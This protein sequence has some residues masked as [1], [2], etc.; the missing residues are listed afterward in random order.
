MSSYPLRSVQQQQQQHQQ[1]T[2]FKD[3][4]YEQNYDANVY[5]PA[6]KPVAP[7]TRFDENIDSEIRA[8]FSS[9][10]TTTENDVLRNAFSRTP[11]PK[12]EVASAKAVWDQQAFLQNLQFGQSGSQSPDLN[13]IIRQ[14]IASPN[15]ERFNRTVDDYLSFYPPGGY[16]M[17]LSVNESPRLD[18]RFLANV[19]H[20]TKMEP[21]LHADP[22]SGVSKLGAVFHHTDT[23]PAGTNLGAAFRQAD[24]RSRVPSLVDNS[25]LLPSKLSIDV[26]ANNVVR[27]QFPPRSTSSRQASRYASTENEEFDAY[28]GR[29]C[30]DT[31]SQ[32][33]EQGSNEGNSRSSSRVHLQANRSDLYFDGGVDSFTREQF[34]PKPSPDIIAHSAKGSSGQRQNSLPYPVFTEPIYR[35]SR[36]DKL[37]QSTESNSIHTQFLASSGNRAPAENAE[38]PRSKQAFKEFMAFFRTRWQASPLEAELYAL[39][40]VDTLPE[41]VRWRVF[42]ELAE[43]AKKM[44]DSSK[45]MDIIALI[46]TC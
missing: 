1:Q 12:K 42:V 32:S 7:S 33:S 44:D 39:E 30:I 36:D 21:V 6:A 8:I 46:H 35:K 24:S 28:G 29:E 26:E 25:A 13:S 19:S 38:S 45:V 43:L 18:N 4:N 15:V 16:E 22:R 20:Q 3:N 34:V 23:R 11:G 17:N 31:F 10:C 41:H 14:A 2:A 37:S 40:T 9:H 27:A 5:Y